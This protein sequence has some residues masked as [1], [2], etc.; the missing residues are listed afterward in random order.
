M[1]DKR[2]LIAAIV[3]VMLATLCA[4]PLFSDEK[5]VAPIKHDSFYRYLQ[6]EYTAMSWADLTV[7]YIAI[8]H[9]KGYKER[10]APARL[11][12]RHPEFIIG[13]QVLTDIAVHYFADLIYK[14]NKK[15]AY[16]FVI[17]MNVA[18]AYVLYHNFKALRGD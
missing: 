8:N 9:I 3:S 11:M 14:D 16:A 12:L 13:A 5:P 17:V 1:R 6:V 15:V 18:R 4:I 7:S 2:F 10:Y